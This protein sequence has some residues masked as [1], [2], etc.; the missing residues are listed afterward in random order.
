MG[1]MHHHIAVATT[2]RD[3]DPK[4]KAAFERVKDFAKGFN[5]SDIMGLGYETLLIGPLRGVMNGYE[6]YIMIPDGSKE[7]WSTSDDANVIRGYFMETM[8]EF[9]DVFVG[10]WGELMTTGNFFNGDNE[11]Y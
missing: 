10:S 2:W 5:K 3:N 1:T 6:S 11:A 9:A 7:G 8:S 4:V